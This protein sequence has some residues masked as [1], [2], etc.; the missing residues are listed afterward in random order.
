M[1]AAVGELPAVEGVRLGIPPRVTAVIRHAA[2]VGW[3]SGREIL[4]AQDG[5]PAVHAIDG[6]K[7]RETAIRVRSGADAFLR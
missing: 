7:R 1:G 2:R 4:V 6:R 3:P 5:R